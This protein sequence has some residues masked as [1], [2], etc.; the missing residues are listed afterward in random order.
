MSGPVRSKVLGFAFALSVIT[1]LDR[2]CI[3]TAAPY[4]TEELGL[5]MLQMSVVF[6]AFTLAYSIFEIPTGWLADTRGARSVLTRIVLWWSAFTILTGS[7][8]S[9][10]SLLVTGSSSV[11]EKRARS[12]ESRAHSP[13]GFHSRNEAARTESFFSALASE[14]PSLPL[15]RSS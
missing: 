3:S 12:P 14:A 15:Y 11:R 7:A 1:Y 6:S 5:T 9:Y 2:V 4:I 10:A 13:G 8:W